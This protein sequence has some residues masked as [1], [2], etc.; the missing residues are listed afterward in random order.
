MNL[1]TTLCLMA[2][3]LLAATSTLA[4]TLFVD[5]TANSGAKSEAS[6]LPDLSAAWPKA[7]KPKP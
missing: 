4:D 7:Q 1:R 5:S 3:P 2:L 6:Y